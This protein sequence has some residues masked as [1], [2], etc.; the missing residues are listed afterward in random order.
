M[1]NVNEV[2]LLPK[3]TK[4]ANIKFETWKGKVPNLKYKPALITTAPAFQDV[5][6]VIDEVTEQA[7]HNNVQV[8]VTNASCEGITLTSF[9]PVAKL[10][11]ISAILPKH[12]TDQHPGSVTK[13]V[14]HEQHAKTG[15]KDTESTHCTSET[16]GKLQLDMTTADKCLCQIPNKF[17]L[18]ISL[19]IITK[20]S[21]MKISI[22]YGTNYKME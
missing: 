16:N 9:A 6:I 8:W 22:L 19:V 12:G 20:V 4:L 17:F 1:V 2:V 13:T 11:L 15:A 10:Q 5:G 7:H 21:F 3:E 18:L 14:K